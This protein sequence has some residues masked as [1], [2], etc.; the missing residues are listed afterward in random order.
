MQPNYHAKLLSQLT[1]T[2]GSAPNI[3]P[4]LGNLLHLVSEAYTEQEVLE[5]QLRSEVNLRTE[6]LIGSTSRAYS[7]LDSLHMGF[8][9]CDVN[10]GVVLANDVVRQLI[11][12][13]VATDAYLTL[14]VLDSVFRPALE[15]QKLVVHCL[16]SGQPIEAATVNVADKVLQ[17]SIAPMT[18]E[19]DGEKQQLGAVILIDDITEQKVL[20]RSKDEFLSIASHELRTPLTA[21]RGNAAL[22]QK[23]FKDRLSPEEVLDMVGEIHS[24]TIRLI[25]IV[26]DFLDASALEQ[27]KMTIEP[28]EFNL[29]EVID[30]V[31]SELQ[32]LCAAKEL[33]L[34]V[35]PST[36]HSL[37]V[38]AD[39]QRTKQV[40]IN[41]V[42][43]A[44]KF[45]EH[46]SITI[47][48]RRQEKFV[49]VFVT[50]TGRGM[51]A[52]SQHLLFRKFQQAGSSLLTRDT[53]KGTG[54]GLYISK[55]ILEQSGGKIWLEQSAPDQGSTFA[56]SLPAE[57]PEAS[58]AS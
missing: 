38:F 33:Q 30:E 37:T 35:E 55:Q 48:A 31:S 12:G 21:I 2:L 8:I 45:T 42:G 20:E 5:Q 54:L 25:E 22:I 9:M 10:G 29:S 41:L 40:L 18:N 19:V 11:A 51:S 32:T 7:F 52:E 13:V 47:S 15:L 1:Q 16:D 49:D 46:G 3:T 58:A 36:P 27:G 44:V 39:R 26:N 34:V 6:Q 4:Q 17:L 53:T 23:H 24:S 56:F 14:T 28:T 43:N 57:A 50:D